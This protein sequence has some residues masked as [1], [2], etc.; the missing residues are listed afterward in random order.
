MAAG[1]IS[2][3]GHGVRR[4]DTALGEVCWGVETGGEFLTSWGG[5]DQSALREAIMLSNVAPLHRKSKETHA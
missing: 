2:H 4:K 3:E 5:V 1:T